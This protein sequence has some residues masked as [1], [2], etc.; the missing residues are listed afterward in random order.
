MLPMRLECLAFAVEDLSRTARFYDTLGIVS[1]QIWEDRRRFFRRD[2]FEHIK[3]SAVDVIFHQGPLHGREPYPA[4]G[5]V[6]TASRPDRGTFVCVTPLPG[7]VDRIVEKAVGAGGRLIVSPRATAW[8]TY[9]STFADPDG[10]HWDV[11]SGAEDRK[12]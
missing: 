8:G 12:R 3:R 7:F 4:D 2:D 6:L 5:D 10:H 11:Y 9:S 1:E